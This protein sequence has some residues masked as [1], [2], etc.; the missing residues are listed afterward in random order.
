[1]TEIL[2]KSRLARPRLWRRDGD[3]ILLE[4]HEGQDAGGES[5]RRLVFLLAGTQGGKTSFGPC[6]LN[7]EINRHRAGDYLAVTS[8]FDLFKLKMLPELRSVF[9]YGLGTGRYWAADKVM[10]LA[11]PSTG[12][13]WDESQNDRMWGRIILRS[14]AFQVGLESATTNAA[15]L[16]ATDVAI[17]RGPSLAPSSSRSASSIGSRPESPLM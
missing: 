8:T 5:V 12:K 2:T 16:A 11:D 10:D 15:C 13:F 17:L 6:W 7:R 3:R 14:A 1:M 4:L 9:E